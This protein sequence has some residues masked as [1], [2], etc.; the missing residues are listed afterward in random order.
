MARFAHADRSPVDATVD[1]FRVKCLVADGSLLFPEQL[2]WTKDNFA[3]LTGAF[4]ENLL[5]DERSFEEKLRTQLADVTDEQVRLMA[6]LI[7]VHYLFVTSV[8]GH[9]KREL[10]SETLS[11]VGES[12]PQGTDVDQAFEAGIGSGGQGF[13]AGRPNLLAYLIDFG[14]RFKDEQ[15][16]SEARTALLAEAWAF[17]AW[18]AGEDGEADGG[19]QMMRHIL[20]HLLFPEDFERISAQDDKYLIRNSL[21]GLVDGELDGDIDRALL[22]IRAALAEVLPEGQPAIGGAIDFYETPLQETWDVDLVPDSEG[23]TERGLSA[24]QSLLHKGQVV[25]FGPPGTGKTYDAKALAERVLRHEGLR[26]WGAVEYLSNEG[27]IRELVAHQIRRL[28]LHQAY[29]YEEFIRGLR[30]TNDGTEPHDGYL[31]RLVDE[32]M[33]DRADCPDPKPLPWILILDELNRTD[34]SRLLGEV[35]S[36]LDD[37]SAPIDLALADATGTTQFRLPEDLLLIGTMNLIDQSVEELDFA[38]RRR[39]LW[40][41]TG[42]KGELIV[43]ILEERWRALDL[44]EFPWMERHSWEHAEGDIELLAERAVALNKLIVSSP[45]LGR[46]YEVGHTYFLD[47]VGLVAR[48]PRVQ[49]GRSI[50]RRYLWSATGRPQPPLIDLWT[51]SLEPLLAE[52]LAGVAPE[53][54]EEQLRTLREAFLAR[55]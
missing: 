36:L 9:R 6:D 12:Y 29:S 49:A 3:A 40:L 46:Q 11:F 25:F 13:N 1:R 8:S 2:L 27:R 7:A 38:L 10:V 24:L 42:F 18:L 48:S 17:K 32:L 39:F 53:A 28:Q 35:F 34:V 54:R 43:P 30:L 37:R 14:R 47:V 31:L 15:E 41:P 16:T 23:G 21:G 19:E 55:Q 4:N 45:L 20:L 44:A 5:T 50:R 52:Y 26:R 33:K 22:Q 51:H